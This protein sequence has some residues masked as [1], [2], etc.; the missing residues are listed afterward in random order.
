MSTRP[1]RT[2]QIRY[3]YGFVAPTKRKEMVVCASL[4]EA[5][6]FSSNGGTLMM[7]EVETRIGEWEPIQAEVSS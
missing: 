5:Q 6:F 7:R 1:K 3:E 4:Q 2:L